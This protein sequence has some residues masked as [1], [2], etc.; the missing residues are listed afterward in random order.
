MKTSIQG[1]LLALFTLLGLLFAFAD[2]LY[3]HPVQWLGH[4]PSRSGGYPYLQYAPYF[5]FPVPP[6]QKEEMREFHNRTIA[7]YIEQETRYKPENLSLSFTV[8]APNKEQLV[9]KFFGEGIRADGVRET[10]EECL[11]FATPLAHNAAWPPLPQY[12]ALP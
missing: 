10:I 6:E 1:V 5:I 11:T 4:T 7:F 12:A 3:H 2:T 8:E 9:V